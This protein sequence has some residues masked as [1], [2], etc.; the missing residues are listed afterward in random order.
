MTDSTID[1]KPGEG[2]FDV[3]SSADELFGEI[4]DEFL[5]SGVDRAA[6]DDDAV[7]SDAESN[8]AT[9]DDRENVE[10]QT[11]AAVFGQLKADIEA[12]DTAAVL[13]DES[14]E[15]I[16]ASADEPDPEPD[17]IDEDLLAD[18]EALTDLLLTGRT[19]EEEF[20]WIDPDDESDEPATD[21]DCESESLEGDAEA[22]DS[23]DAETTLESEEADGTDLEETDDSNEPA[24]TADDSDDLE[25]EDSESETDDDDTGPLESTEPAPME[26]EESE[27]LE[28]GGLED[29]DESIDATDEPAETNGESTEAAV[30][31]KETADEPAASTETDDSRGLIRRLL[32]ALNPF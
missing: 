6:G 30:E 3:G 15:D 19:K 14:P 21:N 17:P 32:S 4:E 22:G 27:S 28:A 1:N 29:D 16:I 5:E 24:I 8:D 9:A 7:E 2:G 10:D 31:S 13:E 11:A 12:E 18:E 25:A 23:A 20:L 26:S